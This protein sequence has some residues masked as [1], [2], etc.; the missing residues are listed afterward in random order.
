MRLQ[1]SK[2]DAVADSSVLRADSDNLLYKM[3]LAN[4]KREHAHVALYDPQV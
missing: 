1:V 2:A 4:S 3:V